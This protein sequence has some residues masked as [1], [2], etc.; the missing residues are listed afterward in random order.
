MFLFEFW[1]SSAIIV[2]IPSTVIFLLIY[3]IPHLGA[4]QWYR[5][6]VGRALAF[7]AGSLALITTLFGALFL[8]HYLHGDYTG[9]DWNLASDAA[10]SI[11][12]FI[13][14]SLWSYA[15]ATYVQLYALIKNRF[16]EKKI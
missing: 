7:S 3:V 10:S 16:L 13:N 9:I 15:F 14:I 2:A 12:I 4:G 6:Y 8:I 5:D 1:R 11:G